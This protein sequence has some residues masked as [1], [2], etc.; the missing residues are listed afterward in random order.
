MYE[1]DKKI[2]SVWLN[3]LFEKLEAKDSFQELSV[4]FEARLDLVFCLECGSD[5]SITSRDFAMDIS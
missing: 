4:G 3:I 5:T 2:M 1:L